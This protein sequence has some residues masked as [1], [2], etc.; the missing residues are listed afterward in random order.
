MLLGNNGS[1]SNSRPEDIHNAGIDLDD[2]EVLDQDLGE[3]GEVDDD[4]EPARKA[5]V[6]TLYDEDLALPPGKKK[7]RR[8]WDI[9]PL[10]TQ[11]RQTGH[12]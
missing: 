4:P 5:R 12:I 11:R 8:M 1:P 10:R 7:E 2:N 6:L 9:I 3:E